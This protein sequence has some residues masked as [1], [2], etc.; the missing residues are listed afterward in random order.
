ML[1]LQ[2]RQS[3][4]VNLLDDRTAFQ[5]QLSPL[6]IEYLLWQPTPVFLPRKS[7][8][9][10]RLMG[11]IPWGC[12]VGHSGSDLACTQAL[13]YTSSLVKILKPQKT[14][15]RDVLSSLSKATQLVSGI[16][17]I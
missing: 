13:L 5:K 17:R 3:W 4:R 1:Q 8:G 10:R 2:I 6:F 9:Q 15:V 11:N 16:A 12:R 14:K 7:H